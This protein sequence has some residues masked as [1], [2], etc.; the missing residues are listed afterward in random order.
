MRCWGGQDGQGAGQPE[1][2]VGGVRASLPPSSC[3]PGGVVWPGAHAGPLHLQVLRSPRIISHALRSP[4][5]VTCWTRTGA[6]PGAPRLPVPG[7]AGLLRRKSLC[8]TQ[9]ANSRCREAS[10]SIR[11]SELQRGAFPPHRVEDARDQRA[12]RRAGQGPCPSQRERPSRRG[13]IPP[14]GDALGEPP[15]RPCPWPAL[16]P[17]QPG[18]QGLPSGS[19]PRG[20]DPSAALLGGRL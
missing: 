3:P 11:A 19:G 15:P 5:H 4:G 17:R 7:E 16:G 8:K 9:T 6:Q 10:P 20:R 1:V 12:L 18:K 2:R 14:P 13:S